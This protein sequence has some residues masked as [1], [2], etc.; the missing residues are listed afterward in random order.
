MQIYFWEEMCVSVEIKFKK[1]QILHL[2]HFFLDVVL[3]LW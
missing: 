2:L 1:V 3:T